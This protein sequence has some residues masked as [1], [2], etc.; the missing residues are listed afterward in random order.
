MKIVLAPNAFKDSLTA[1]EACQAM[2]EGIHDVDPDIDVIKKPVA[3]GGDGLVDI[4]VN[5]LNA[6]I[7]SCET[8]DPLF[9]PITAQFCFLKEQKTAV[10][11]MAASSG[12]R[13]LSNTERN[14]MNTSTYGTGLLIRKA[15]D[16][17]AEKILVGI[18]GSATNDGGTGMAAALGVQ[19]K[20][21]KGQL[22][23]PKG[24]ELNR[25]DS[26]D[27]SALDSRIH[28]VEIEAICDVTNPLLGK[29]GAAAVYA[30]QKGATQQQVETLEAGMVHLADQLYKS[31]G[32]DVTKIRSG[33]AAGGLGAG[34]YAFLGA[35]IKTGI[36]IVLELVD[37]ASD[38]RECD[39]V[40]TGEGQID[41]QTS[42]GKAPAGVAQMCR[43][44][45]CPCIAITG[46][47]GNAVADLHE[48]GFTAIFSL[49]NQPMELKSAIKNA[50]S[51]LRQETAQAFRAF[52]GLR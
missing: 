29:E 50:Y 52:L 21:K 35:E 8:Q 20:D 9:R 18:G 26:I 38:L 1:V 19:F 42:Y 28:Q 24:S 14:P 39:L 51:L 16:L 6:E 23:K 41:G 36:E 47:R 2:A 49:C 13:L 31:I 4:L 46:S 48:L 5:N 12:L 30:P 7:I 34:L 27:L 43:Q 37:L 15:L 33:G 10:I 40:L 17:G 25:I 44:Q 45:G 3:D 32:K 22:I 11:E